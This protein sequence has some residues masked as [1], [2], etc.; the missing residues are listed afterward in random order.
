MWTRYTSWHKHDHL[1]RVEAQNISQEDHLCPHC[2]QR[3]TVQ[4]GNEASQVESRGDCIKYDNNLA[5]PTA[6]LTTVKYHLKSI[7]STP[8]SRYATI[9]IKDLYLGTPMQVYEYMLVML[10]DIPLPII[11]YYN[12]TILAKNGYV[13]VVIQ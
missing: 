2:H 12:L 1:H 8:G 3:T 9:D 4:K 13:L 7:I 5:T 10:S 6:N 11:K